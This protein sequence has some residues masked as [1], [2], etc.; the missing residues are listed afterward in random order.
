VA[1]AGARAARDSLRDMTGQTALGSRGLLSLLLPLFLAGPAPAAGPGAAPPGGGEIVGGKW[2]PEQLLEHDPAW[3]AG[4][5]LEI[6]ASELWDGKGGLLEAVVQVGGCSSGFVSPDGLLLTN[7][8]C[9]FGILQQHSSPER[10]LIRDGFLAAERSQELPGKGT[11]AEIPHRFEDVTAQ[12]EGSVPAGADDLERYEAIDR[13]QKD[14][15]AACEA[16]AD[17]RCRVAAYDDGVRYTLI[18]ALEYPDVRLVYAPPRAVGEY[19]G[20]V[21]NWMWPRHTGD[22]ALLRVYAAGGEP[23][24]HGPDNTPYRP[25]RHLRIAPGGVAEGS[26]VMVVGYPGSTS[27][28]LVAAEMDERFRLFFPR[29]A[30]LYRA[31]MDLLEARSG[32]DEAAA[33]TLASR[34]KGLANREKS[35]RGQVAGIE[36]GDLVAKKRRAEAEVLAWAR[37][38]PEHRAAVAA[39]DGLTALAEEALATWDRDF[40]VHQIDSGPLPLAQAIDLVRWAREGEKP[41]RER[42]PEFQERNRSRARDRLERDQ[43]R[44]DLPAEELLLLDLLARFERLEGE[45]RVAALEPLLAAAGGERERRVA[46]LLAA[47]RVPLLEERL[48]ML[49]ES[50]AELAAR[51]DPLLALATA[52][53]EEVVEP[54]ELRE[55]RREGAESR[56]RPRWR[57]A[58]AAHAGRPV[59]PDANGTL[60]VSLARVAGYSPRDGVWMTPVTRL[61]GVVEKH[62][63]EEPFAAPEA[64]LAGA[65]GAAASRWADPALG[66]VPVCFLATGDTTGG[67]SGSPVL[68][69][70]GDL[71]GV[72]FDRVWEN[73]ANDFG[74]NPE[75]AR[76]VAAD[77]RYLLWLL[78]GAR[79][80]GS[81]ALLRELGVDAA[82]R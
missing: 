22:F 62:T 74:Y 16:P 26:F 43:T 20:E 1:A 58:V 49:D 50:A 71:V 54:L 53:V 60:R 77:V 5:G 37:D 34:L 51:G 14:L 72:N 4:L 55:K 42:R 68:D 36:R 15:V 17:R 25:R 78:D 45:Q 67:S 38:R 33:I 8:H 64:V 69:G 2:T 47:S 44:L 35:S 65:A 73:V 23:A 70:R 56:L 30:E 41:D 28:R 12:I 48:A 19:G 9:A 76:N 59:A 11:R 79:P 3:L 81:E 21:D 31:W 52:L 75:I 29:R 82:T 32:A 66:D 6:P 27:R 46:E 57:T 7:H 80:A 10:D 63:G 39:Y 18:E 24:P 40:L 61:A 13:A